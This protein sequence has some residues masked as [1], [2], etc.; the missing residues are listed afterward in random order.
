[1]END[2]GNVMVSNSSVSMDA[3]SMN[4]DEIFSS[5]ALSDR[6]LTAAVRA[7]SRFSP[8]FPG[9]FLYRRVVAGVGLFDRPLEAWAIMGARELARAEKGNGRRYI[10]KTTRTKNEWVAQAGRDALDYVIFGKYAA[11]ASERADLFGIDEDTYR[12]IRDPIGA[13][14][15]IGLESFRSL[16]H[17]E[18]WKLFYEKFS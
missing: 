18:Y 2:K 7:S 16:I 10:N 13:S 9:W 17:A 3:R 15:W 12:K 11:S 6:A 14:M 8:L 5:A 4:T 1:M